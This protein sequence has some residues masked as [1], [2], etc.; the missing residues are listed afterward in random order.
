[1]VASSPSIADTRR[2][3][4][5][6][7]L[8]PLEIERIRRFGAV[9]SYGADEALAKVG[10]ANDG[11]IIVLAGTVDVTQHDQF[12]HRA[13]IVTHGPGAFLGELAQLSGRRALVRQ[14]YGSES[15]EEILDGIIDRKR[16]LNRLVEL[17]RKMV[18]S[19]QELREFQVLK[20]QFKQYVADLAR[21]KAQ[22]RAI[23]AKNLTAKSV[24][25]T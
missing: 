5:F 14:L 24:A 17:Q 16:R 3:Q 15:I 1:M 12:G 11:L 20:Q 7:V 21:Q 13:P 6:P 9:R 23:D 4:M 22:S 19:A 18:L 8:E 10:Q 2:H 25:R